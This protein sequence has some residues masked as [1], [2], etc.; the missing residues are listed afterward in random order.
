[1]RKLIYIIIAM[2]FSLMSFSQVKDLPTESNF[3]DFLNGYYSQKNPNIETSKQIER[4]QIKYVS[5]LS[6]SGDCSI[7]AEAIKNYAQNYSLYNS[8]TYNPGWTELGSC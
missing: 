6:P 5:K 8:E 4:M 7:A 2:T 1:M 3:Y